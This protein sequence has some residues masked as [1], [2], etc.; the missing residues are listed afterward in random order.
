MPTPIEINEVL[1]R[2]TADLDQLTQATREAAARIASV[3]DA[4]QATTRRTQRANNLLVRS[5]QRLGGTVR[6]L[7]RAIF[8]FKGLLAGIAAGALAT[9]TR[10]TAESADNIAKFS[11]ALGVSV[12]DLSELK[13]AAERSGASFEQLQ[14]GLR[15][16]QKNLTEFTRLGTGEAAKA[17]T[18]TSERFQELVRQGIPLERLIPELS[19]EFK[20][21]SE[22]DRVLLATK[23][24]GESGTALIPLLVD[25]VESLI[26]RARE[27]GA[28]LSTDLA[29]KSEDFNDAIL[30]LSTSLKALVRE[31]ITPILPA[32]T[33]LIDFIT[34]RVVSFRQ[35]VA[36]NIDLVAISFR[37]LA[38]IRFDAF[39][40]AISI[41]PTE[42]TV[43]ALKNAAENLFQI[44]DG[45]RSAGSEAARAALDQQLNKAA[46]AGGELVD[47]FGDLSDSVTGL[48]FS[49][50]DLDTSIKIDIEFPNFEEE[51]ARI[52]ENF[53][54]IL[55]EEQQ[56]ALKQRQLEILEDFKI[57]L[58]EMQLTISDFALLSGDLLDSFA[59]GFGDAI[60]RVIV[61]GES[62][63]EALTN[64]L[65]NLA[66]QIISA[67]TQLLV[68]QLIYLIARNLLGVQ[69]V[70]GELARQAA[71]TYA[72]AYASTL[73]AGGVAG[74]IAAPIVAEAQVLAMLGGAA[75]AAAQGKGAGAGIGSGAFQFGGIVTQPTLA[76]IGEAGQ[77]EAVI[78]LDRLDEFVGSTREQHIQVMLDER[79]I[80][81]TVVRGMP[82]RI[83]LQG[84]KGL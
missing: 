69:T 41:A 44:A 19:R 37:N 82:A 13:F 1:T 14:V 27:L 12:G 2:F 71:I 60:A 78:P 59:Q 47:V 64:L 50:L 62:L 36:E 17:L 58:L 66:A 53:N 51:A 48:D 40:G 81:D 68:E 39:G 30:D 61:F 35:S 16:A 52:V 56:Q 10:S 70:S 73:A 18:L 67:L 57:F 79:V 77:N 15:Q 43:N 45:L 24:F 46:D 9:L 26:R 42:G 34:A 83:R 28:T 29:K 84:V 7:G 23:L 8:S 4:S 72:A 33:A 3:G 74:F 65:K 6:T 55:G 11:K 32:L 49:N 5:F 63:V 21:L 22:A 54:R 31:A 75:G 25:D 80:V 76:L 20:K 38:A